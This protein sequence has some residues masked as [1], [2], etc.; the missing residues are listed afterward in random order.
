MDYVQLIPPQK[1]IGLPPNCPPPKKNWFAPQ[2]PP[3]KLVPG[4]AT[5]YTPGGVYFLCEDTH[6]NYDWL[7][8]ILKNKIALSNSKKVEILVPK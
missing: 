2:L 7:N 4:A 8:M 6:V 5:G 3:K 1:R